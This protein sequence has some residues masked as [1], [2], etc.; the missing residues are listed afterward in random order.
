MH[1]TIY[2]DNLV[3][4]KRNKLKIDKE[5]LINDCFVIGRL[6]NING[7]KENGNMRKRYNLIF[8]LLSAENGLNYYA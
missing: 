3:I 4:D 5:Q 7:A 8:Q 2:Y 6:A 1:I